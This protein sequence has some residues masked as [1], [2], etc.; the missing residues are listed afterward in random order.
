MNISKLNRGLKKV[1]WTTN[2]ALFSV[3]LKS[4][5]KRSTGKQIIIYHGVTNN[6]K[7][8]IN[9]RF[10]SA[11]LF[12]KQIAYFKQHF[13]VVTLHDYF[14]GAS[15]PNKLTLAITFDDG[16]L[17]NLT[18]ALPILEKHSVS[19]T[20]FITTIQQFESTI[21]W[22][23]ALDLYRYTILKN[24]FEFKGVVYQKSN[25]EFISKHGLLKHFLKKSDWKI[26]KQLVE[27]ILEDNLFLKNDSLKPYHQLLSEN[28]IVTLSKS[29]YA[30]IGSH[31]LYHNCLTEV[32]LGDARDELI[33]SKNYLENITQKE[34]TNFA[35][36]DGDY[37]QKLID[38]VEDVGYK[39]QLVVN[40]ISE[41][42][43]ADKRLENRFGIN[44]YISFNNQIQCLI[45]GKY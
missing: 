3:G 41:Q 8:D 29:S 28:D 25:N 40:Y 31:A 9:A 27:L 4:L 26:K 34:V 17:N 11:Q 18:E 15:H 39:N 38:C 14:N 42:D 45:N 2:D 37:N 35:Y 24:T 6:A 5:S 10:I 13:N 16:Y 23:D 7:T 43:K 32:A 21:L 1:K 19:A 33:I 20:F 36:P 30:E 22:A 12:E 44:P